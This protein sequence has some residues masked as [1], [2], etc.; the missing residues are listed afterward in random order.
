MKKSELRQLIREEI[1]K[2][3]NEN[4]KLN[5]NNVKSID[6]A[7]A[8]FNGR[9]LGRLYK[10]Y[11]YMNN[12]TQNSYRTVGQFNDAFGTE[13]PDPT[14]YEEFKEGIE[15]LNPKIEV[16]EGEYDVS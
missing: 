15:Q 6:Y 13:L 10:L 1:S 5:I 11:V 9:S 4:S 14:H 7:I 8:E 16:T 2:V 12:G 3:M